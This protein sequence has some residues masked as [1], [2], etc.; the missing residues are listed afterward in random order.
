M[1]RKFDVQLGFPQNDS[2]DSIVLEGATFEENLEEDEFVEKFLE[3]LAE[4]I[5]VES[6]NSSYRVTLTLTVRDEVEFVFEDESG[7]Y[8]D[9][10]AVKEAVERGDIDWSEYQSQS[11]LDLEVEGVEVED[12]E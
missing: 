1:A 6:V 11:D 5:E 4:N 7:E 8:E 12:N 9:A 3:V 2:R 10:D